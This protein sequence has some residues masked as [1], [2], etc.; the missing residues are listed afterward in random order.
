M[1]QKMLQ[2]ITAGSVIAGML[3]GIPVQAAETQSLSDTGYLTTPVT[4]SI[5]DAYS[6]SNAEAETFTVTIPKSIE[7]SD[8][9]ETSYEI[10][11]EGTIQTTAAYGYVWKTLWN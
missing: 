8:T 2:L 7:L 1:K 10:T 3:S 11:V 9:E 5:E 6:G 4:L